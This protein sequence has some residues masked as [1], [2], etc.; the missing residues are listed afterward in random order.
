MVN[1]AEKYAEADKQRK[2]KVEAVNTTESIIHDIETK[3]E[4][5]KDQLPP[6]EVCVWIT[7]GY[8]TCELPDTLHSLGLTAGHKVNA[9]ELAYI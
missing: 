4:E 9:R 7:R 2:Q 8:T 6:D 5:F 3:T 1:E